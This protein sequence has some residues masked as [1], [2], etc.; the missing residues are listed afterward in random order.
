MPLP[1]GVAEHQI[2]IL[3]VYA[4]SNAISFLMQTSLSCD[5][6]FFWPTESAA[7]AGATQSQ[8]VQLIQGGSFTRLAFSSRTFLEAYHRKAR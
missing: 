1:D 7:D 2:R 5:V 8:L 6:G 3:L 4:K